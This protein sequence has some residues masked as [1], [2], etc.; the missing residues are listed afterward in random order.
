MSKKHANTTAVGQADLPRRRE[1]DSTE[2]MRKVKERAASKPQETAPTAPPPYTVSKLDVLAQAMIV[3]QREINAY[4]SYSSRPRA[5]LTSLEEQLAETLARTPVRMDVGQLNLLQQNVQNTVERMQTKPQAA[6]F[7]LMADILQQALS[8]MKEAKPNALERLQILGQQHTAE[9]RAILWKGFVSPTSQQAPRSLRP[10]EIAEAQAAAEAAAEIS[11]FYPARTFVG[12]SPSPK[13][14][15]PNQ[16]EEMAN[17]ELVVAPATPELEA[18]KAEVPAAAAPEQQPKPRT[19]APTEP[20]PVKSKPTPKPEKPKA[21]PEAHRPPAMVNQWRDRHPSIAATNPVGQRYS[22]SQGAASSTDFMRA[23][24]A[25]KSW[26]DAHGYECDALTRPAELREATFSQ[27]LSKLTP[28]KNAVGNGPGKK[29]YTALVESHPG[30]KLG[31]GEVWGANG[32]V[33]G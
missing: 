33:R 25:M 28:V 8:T 23:S 27:L 7:T 16:S 13:V 11:R 3:A 29:L 19:A 21:K 30:A 2:L 10:H 9:Q 4:A 6:K 31:R 24:K 12:G 26:L 18:P 1:I 20:N 14:V 17:N 22:A 5:L 15:V 32:V